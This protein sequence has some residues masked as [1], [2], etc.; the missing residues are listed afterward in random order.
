MDWGDESAVSNEEEGQEIK[1]EI[2]QELNEGVEEKV[3]ERIKEDK[4]TR[5]TRSYSSWEDLEPEIR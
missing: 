3:E 5:S 4:K 1:E 2:K